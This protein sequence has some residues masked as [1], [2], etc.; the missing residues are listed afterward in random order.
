[1]RL[2]NSLLFVF[3]AAFVIVGCK[4]TTA[5]VIQAEADPLE[6]GISASFWT[7]FETWQNDSIY[8]KEHIIFPLKGLPAS[9]E[10]MIE[11]ESFYWKKDSW[12][13]HRQFD[14]MG[15]TFKRRYTQMGHLVTETISDQ[16]GTFQ[17]ERRFAKMDEEWMMIYYAAMRMVR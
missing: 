16:S 17:M 7:F 5:P 10:E 15:G 9:S 13:V 14:D 4:D 11:G 8:Q 1:M 2:K 12:L 6:N 3:F